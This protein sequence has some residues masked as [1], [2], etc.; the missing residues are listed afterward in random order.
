MGTYTPGTPGRPKSLSDTLVEAEED[1]LLDCPNA[2]IPLRAASLLLDVILFSLANSGIQNFFETMESY[3]LHV[4]HAGAGDSIGHTIAVISMYL[5]LVTKVS[6]AYLF[7][8]WSL[9]RFRGSPGKLLLG[10]RVVD[11]NTGRPLRPSIALMREAL[12][13]PLSPLSLIGIAGSLFRE[14]HRPLHDKV[15]GSVVKRLHGGPSA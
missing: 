3:A 5:T 14:E 11:A 2:D 10:L 8:V 15:A 7:F 9:N 6:G 12:K 1:H 13:I 4:V